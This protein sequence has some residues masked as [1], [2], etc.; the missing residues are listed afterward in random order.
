MIVF[1]IYK[2][3]IIVL[4]ICIYLFIL[5]CQIVDN[6]LGWPK[7]FLLGS[8]SAPFVFFFSFS[9]S[10]K[11]QLCQFIIT[12]FVSPFLQRLA[13]TI[14]KW[15]MSPPYRHPSR[16]CAFIRLQLLNICCA[17]K[18]SGHSSIALVVP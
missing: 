4:N 15:H 11:C 7:T 12:Y 14:A 8:T 9:L 3:C 18:I 2:Y 16:N 10:I 6:L 1:A 17:S 13:R 5:F